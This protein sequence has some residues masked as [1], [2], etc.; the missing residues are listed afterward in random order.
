MIKSISIQEVMD[1]LLDNPLLSKLTLERVVNY[2]IV[3][4]QKVGVPKL[5][6]D[7]QHIQNQMSIDVCCHVISMR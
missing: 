5:Y 4:M 1:D 3:F 7:K 6:T 2:A